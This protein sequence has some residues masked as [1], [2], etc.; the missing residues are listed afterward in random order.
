MVGLTMWLASEL[1]K[2]RR[3]ATA[4][5]RRLENDLK[6]KRFEITTLQ[7]LR[8]F[9]PPKVSGTGASDA[10]KVLHEL[11]EQMSGFIRASPFFMLATADQTG[12]P[13]C[14]P[15]GD[16]PG[17]V[18]IVDSKTLL[19]PDRPGNR[20]IIGLQNI[21]ENPKVGLCFEIPGT[22]STLRVGG[23]AKISKDPE[24]CSRLRTR[25]RDAA[26]VIIVHL[27]YCFFHCGKAYLRSNKW[28]PEHW[29]K[30]PYKVGFG[31]Y[32]TSIGTAA[33]VIDHFVEK[34]YEMVQESMEGKRV[35]PDN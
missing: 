21:L 32:F 6:A 24:L 9:L 22:C 12:L 33:T 20:L 1:Y 19:I 34:E 8:D 35:E 2:R 29:A 10:P 25:G 13:F 27:K 18:E 31:Q 11:D 15:K 14:S 26:L 5:A 23:T 17:F 3:L 16:H 28:R 30:I 7:E 4:A